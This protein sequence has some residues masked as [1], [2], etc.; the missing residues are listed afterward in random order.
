MGAAASAGASLPALLLVSSILLSVAGDRGLRA[1]HAGPSLS[2]HLPRPGGW[3]LYGPFVAL[4]S[5]ARFPALEVRLRGG[6]GIGK[7]GHAKRNH[8]IAV[9][10][11]EEEVEEAKD[12]PFAIDDE[13]V[14]ALLRRQVLLHR[15]MAILCHHPHDPARQLCHGR[16]SPASEMLPSAGLGLSAASLFS[17]SARPP[18][19]GV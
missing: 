8:A 2:I 14:N 11:V 4:R 7:K 9:K 1:P 12:S 3:D 17:T 5:A 6:R 18:P 10:E 13:R 19:L 16:P 15:P